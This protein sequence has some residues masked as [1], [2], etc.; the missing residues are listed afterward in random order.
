MLTWDGNFVVFTWL[1]RGGMN[2]SVIGRV[3]PGCLAVGLIVSLSHRSRATRRRLSV[4]QLAPWP[5]DVAAAATKPPRR[6]WTV[7]FWGDFSKTCW[8]YRDGAG[9][10]VSSPHDQFVSS[11]CRWAVTLVNDSWRSPAGVTLCREK[12]FGGL[13][14]TQFQKA[15][16]FLAKTYP[17]VRSVSSISRQIRPSACWYFGIVCC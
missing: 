13:G 4:C 14:M 17:T 2:Y 9:G 16:R 7:R 8:R 3:A 10:V 6:L 5:D 11:L 15:D 12:R 1:G